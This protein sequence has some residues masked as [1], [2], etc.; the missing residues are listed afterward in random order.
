VLRKD[1]DS[2][3]MRHYPP[4]MPDG[5]SENDLQARICRILEEVIGGNPHQWFMF[6]DFWAPNRD[7]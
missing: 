1:D 5:E 6:R 3:V 4:I 7:S 2:F